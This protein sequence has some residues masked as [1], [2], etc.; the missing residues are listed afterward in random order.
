MVYVCMAFTQQWA[1][2]PLAL[3][4]L[5]SKSISVAHLEK[6]GGWKVDVGFDD[7]E[8]RPHVLWTQLCRE[9]GRGWRKEG[10][11][12]I[13]SSS[14]WVARPQR[15]RE[16]ERERRAKKLER[17]LQRQTLLFF[18]LSCNNFGSARTAGALR[19]CSCVPGFG[20]ELEEGWRRAGGHSMEGV[21]PLGFDSCRGDDSVGG[22]SGWWAGVR[23]RCMWLE[24]NGCALPMTFWT[25]PTKGKQC[26]YWP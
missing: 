18:F 4:L 8:A 16:R 24:A 11:K 25:T 26:K 6:L 12:H 15:R 17:A 13:T 7:L 3:C 9:R 14:L 21:G 19:Y 22:S 20:L 1:D 10:R 5:Q 23:L 2:F